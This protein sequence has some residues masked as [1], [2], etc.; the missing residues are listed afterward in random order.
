MSGEELIKEI[1]CDPSKLHPWYDSLRCFLNYIQTKRDK[2]FDV[3][4][5]YTKIP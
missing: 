3:L 4:E 2:K 5:I 1:I